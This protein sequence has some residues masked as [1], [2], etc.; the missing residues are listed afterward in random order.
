MKLFYLSAFLLF[1]SCFAA[2]EK[3]HSGL[4]K[5]KEGS[6]QFT[7]ENPCIR[8]IKK[9]PV[10]V[11]YDRCDRSGAGV[12]YKLYYPARD[13][14][15]SIDAIPAGKYFVTIQ[16][17]GAHQ[18]HFETVVKIKSGKCSEVPIS[19]DNIDEFSKNGVVIPTEHTDFSNLKITSMK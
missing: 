6:T 12:I 4:V 15:I 10:L 13:H 7:F 9:N 11:I 5:T 19:M 1:I 17:M 3:G 16:C 14:T 18:L 8:T 2:A